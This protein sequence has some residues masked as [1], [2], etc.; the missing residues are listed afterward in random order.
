MVREIDGTGRQP[1][2][3]DKTADA[4]ERQAGETSPPLLEQSVGI[5]ARAQDGEQFVDLLGDRRCIFS[6]GKKF[7]LI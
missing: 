3:G 2:A 1:G 4:R 6:I 5:G 7:H